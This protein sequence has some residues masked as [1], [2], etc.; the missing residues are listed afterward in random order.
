MGI[1]CQY[2]CK[3][4]YKDNKVSI[5]NNFPLRRNSVL[6]N[7]PPSSTLHDAEIRAAVA[8]ILLTYRQ[9]LSPE[10]A[11]FYPDKSISPILQTEGILFESWESGFSSGDVKTAYPLRQIYTW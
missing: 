11:N 1:D 7:G 9:Q 4:P 6:R 8:P 3:V 5:Y 2:Y 10:P